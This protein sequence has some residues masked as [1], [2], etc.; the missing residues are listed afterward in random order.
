MLAACPKNH[1]VCQRLGNA[2]QFA[3]GLGFSVLGRT[4][5]HWQTLVAN[6]NHY[7]ANIHRSYERQLAQLHIELIRGQATL[8]D[9]K[10]VAVDQHTLTSEH[11]LLATGAT[12]TRPDI[13]G[14]ELGMDSDDFLLC[15]QCQKRLPLLAQATSPWN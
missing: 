3:K 7:I 6:R 4:E 5:H 15:K 14:A 12:S 13:P 1:V 10:T 2:N 9:A 8:L 11:I